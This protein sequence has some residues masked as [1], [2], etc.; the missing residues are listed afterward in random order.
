MNGLLRHQKGSDG[1]KRRNFQAFEG[2][3]WFFACL[4]AK[5]GVYAFEKEKQGKKIFLYK[6]EGKLMLCEGVK[7]HLGGF[8]E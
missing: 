1:P 8:M 7:K 5:K 2:F 4:M 3:S 6:Y